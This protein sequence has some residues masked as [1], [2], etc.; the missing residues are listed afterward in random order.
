[1]AMARKTKAQT[2]QQDD[3]GDWR[4][5][6]AKA[7]QAKQDDKAD[8][9]S[10]KEGGRPDDQKGD[11]GIQDHTTLLSP[12]P[13]PGP[14]DL[15][16][17]MKRQQS[18]P[19]GL[20]PEIDEEK[21]R[22]RTRLDPDTGE[23]LLPESI[24]QRH[25][26]QFEAFRRA[27]SEGVKL[28][29]G[30]EGFSRAEETERLLREQWQGNEA[31]LGV[32]R[33]VEEEPVILVR[34]ADAPAEAVDPAKKWNPNPGGGPGV[35]A[36]PALPAGP[37]ERHHVGAAWP[38]PLTPSAAAP[39]AS[40]EPGPEPSQQWHEP[41]DIV[42][43]DHDA[44]VRG[45]LGPDAEQQRQAA[46][47]KLAREGE[48]IE[49]QPPFRQPSDEADPDPSRNSAGKIKHSYVADEMIKTGLEAFKGDPPDHGT[50]Q[51]AL[52]YAQRRLRANWRTYMA[53]RNGRQ[54]ERPQE[55]EPEQQP[56]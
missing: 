48:A 40:P 4:A 31:M 11:Y 16:E 50:L 42:F 19:D 28:R 44:A 27:R 17:E 21:S 37:G 35:G 43:A 14:D 2:Q 23:T 54:Q 49:R 47:E 1:M 15:G 5:E 26:E 13:D 8:W 10:G 9:R 53:E 6:L 34:A 25:E 39:S 56:A 38:A 36:P 30:D 3:D 22:E 18:K 33:T 52:L 20:N 7:K 55:P 46:E 45:T 41:Q 29:E 51:Q 24:E 12:S 32:G